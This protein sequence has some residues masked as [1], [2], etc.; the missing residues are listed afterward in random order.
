MNGLYPFDV[1]LD[2]PQSKTL[3]DTW[4]ESVKEPEKTGKFAVI[5]H[6]DPINGVDY[7]TSVIRSVFGTARRSRFGLCSR[8]ISPAEVRCG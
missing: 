4:L 7:V 6:N 1:N 8:P 2:D 3:V 5:L